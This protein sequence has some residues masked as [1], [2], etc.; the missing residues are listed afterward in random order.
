[1]A[2][3]P[4]TTAVPLQAA[5]STVVPGAA[6]L[7]ER[8]AVWQAKGAAHDRAVRRKMAIAAPILIAVAAVVIYL[9][10]GR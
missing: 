5:V 8:W 10:L 7:D 2:F 1:M 3:D 9:L 6:S 4:P